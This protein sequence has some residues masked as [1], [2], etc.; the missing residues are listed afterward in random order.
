MELVLKER[1]VAVPVSHL[2]AP[3]NIW[4]FIRAIFWRIYSPCHPFFRD[5]FLKAG[6]VHHAGRQ[7]A[8]LG[9]LAPGVDM[10]AFVEFLTSEGWGNHFM[11]WVDE[12]EVLSVRRLDGPDRQYH[13]RVFKDREVRGHYEFTPEAHPVRHMREDESVPRREVFLNFLGDWIEP[14]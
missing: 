7:H 5:L 11:A 1:K 8:L 3:Q 12:G 4:E 6:L 2:P 13:L 14:I 9:K 10:K